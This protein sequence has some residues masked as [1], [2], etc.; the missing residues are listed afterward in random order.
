MPFT[1]SVVREIEQVAEDRDI[2]PAKLLAVVDVESAGRAFWKIG[3]RNLPAVRP[4]AHKFYDRLNGAKRKKAVAA[5]LANPRAGA[6]KVPGSWAA[7][8]DVVE[9]M[10]A[11]D[12]SAAYESC[13]WGVG[14]VMGFHWQRLGY[15]SVEALVKSCQTVEGQV[16]C[17]VRYVEEFKLRDELLQGGSSAASW[18]AFAKA[19]NG[20][21]G[22][23]RGYH[24]L[25]AAAYKRYAGKSPTTAG[26][27][28]E[29][30]LLIQKKLKAAGYYAGSLDGI[31][32]PKTVAAI[33]NFQKDQG[34]VVDGKF[35]PKTRDALDDFLEQ[36]N[37][38]QADAL[39]QQGGGTLAVDVVGSQ[40]LEQ[41]SVLQY[42]GDGSQ[43]I[44]IIVAVVAVIGVGLLLYGLYK[45]F[46][47]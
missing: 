38:Q 10:V 23:S 32:G 4:E 15:P 46:K 27:S 1:S 44:Q 47:S 8:Y 7:V 26:G 11:I 42:L 34:L 17:M 6:I 16:D 18:K 30:V 35:G 37:S 25:M 21:A 2:E 29:E 28:D 20:P 36:R 39:V 3:G 19:Y 31:S 41:T 22:V 9:R 43:V 24:K 13:S 14:Q 33:R 45:K 40:V 12:R 5:G